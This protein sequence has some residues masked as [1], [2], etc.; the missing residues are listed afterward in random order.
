VSLAPDGL[1]AAIIPQHVRRAT[2]G[3]PQQQQRGGVTD[4][5]DEVGRGETA[6]RQRRAAEDLAMTENRPARGPTDSGLQ[7]MLS[8]QC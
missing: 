8:A 2:R 3:E 4:E 5:S 1:P 7:C 6:G